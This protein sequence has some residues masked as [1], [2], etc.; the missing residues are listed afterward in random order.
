MTAWRQRIRPEQLRELS[1]VVLIAAALLIFGWQIENFLSA[2]TFNRIATSVAIVGMVAIGQTLVVLTRNIDLSVG[3]IVGFTA[4]FVGSQL[5]ANNAM[6]A[7]V[8]V[9]LAVAVGGLMGLINGLIVAYGRVPAIITT[10]GTLA[11]YRMLLI[12]YANARTV[13]VDSLPSWVVDFSRQTLLSIGDFAVR[14]L[15]VVTLATV[16]VFQF[17][18]GYTVFGRRLYAIGSNPEAAR[19][20][21]LPAQRLVLIA[22]TLCGMLAGLAGFLFL[23]RFGTITAVAG[24]GIELESVAAVVVGGVNTFGGSGTALGALLGAFLIDLLGQGLLRWLGISEFWRDAL[25]G[26]LILLAVASD[27]VILGWLRQ[28][29]QRGAEVNHGR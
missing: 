20:A 28:L 15:M 6:G 25:L 17:V 11:I 19:F 16:V 27:A 21:G 14:P 13:T 7:P 2:R 29:W 8:A 18:L 22:F 26:L 1:L 10:L 23:A 4:Y 12:N 3:S 9:A 24:Q 5:A